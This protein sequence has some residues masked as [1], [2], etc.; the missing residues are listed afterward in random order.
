MGGETVAQP[1]LSIS[2]TESGE[3]TARGSG[4]TGAGEPTSD[5]AAHGRY[6]YSAITRRPDFS[7]PGG[8]RLAVYVALNLEHFAFGE[9]LGAELCPGGPQPDRKS[10][11]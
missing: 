2:R 7:W 8:K 1:G 5:L 6:R 3:P 9:G 10:V 4:L 11:V